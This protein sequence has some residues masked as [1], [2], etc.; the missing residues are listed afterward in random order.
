[1][2]KKVM[3]LITITTHQ[4]K[5]TSS[6]PIFLSSGRNEHQLSLLARIAWEISK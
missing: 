3:S 2:D 5:V 6:F 4:I 1:M